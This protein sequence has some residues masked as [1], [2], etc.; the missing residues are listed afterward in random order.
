MRLVFD[1]V[2]F[3]AKFKKVALFCF[4]ST[5]LCESDEDARNI[6]TRNDGERFRVSRIDN[7]FYRCHLQPYQLTRLEQPRCTVMS[8]G[9]GDL[10]VDVPAL[11]ARVSEIQAQFSF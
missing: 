5:M 11:K 7:L 10:L 3:D 6:A 9:T 2:T 8:V 1:V 4:H